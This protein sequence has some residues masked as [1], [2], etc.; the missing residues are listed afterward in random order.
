VKAIVLAGGLGTRLAPLTNLVN[1]H[2]LPVGG[3]PM[4]YHPLQLIAKS[5]FKEVMVVVGQ[6]STGDLVR[7]IGGDAAKLGFQSVYFA[8]QEKENG[9]CGALALARDYAA[10][11][12]VFVILG[13]NIFLEAEVPN[14]DV[15]TKARD[16]AVAHGVS[17]FITA[18]ANPKAYGCPVY[19]LNGQI[20]RVVEKPDNP[21]T[22]DI[23]TGAYYFD[24][25]VFVRIDGLSYSERGQLEIAEL[26]NDYD[27][28]IPYM[29]IPEGKW[30]DA[31]ESLD[32]YFR[33]NQLIQTQA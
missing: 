4:I 26:I 20:L 18:V 32:A 12:F 3:I 23:V 21:Q 22:S 13:D 10:R 17:L 1:K 14:M 24:P 28:P 9:I 15:V 11:D 19:G 2:L 6:K 30:I 33:A 7:Q 5:G 16:D 8:Y 31:G 27:G 25:T 29:R